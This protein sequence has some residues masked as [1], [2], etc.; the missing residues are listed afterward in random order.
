[1][2]RIFNDL[3]IMLLA[4]LWIVPVL[5]ALVGALFYF[6]APPPPM[7]ARLATGGPNGGYHA[8]GVKLQTELAREGFTLELVPS[9]GSLD[10]L[11]KLQA[12]EV[13]LALVQ[14]G[15][16][17]NLDATERAHLFGLGVMYQ[18]PVWLF[19]RQDVA[20]KRLADLQ[21]L[22]VAIGSADSG[23]QSLTLPLLEVNGMESRSLPDKWRQIG[24]GR[25]AK[26]L[27]NG[28]LDAAFFIGP[29]ENAL[30]QRLAANPDLQLLDLRRS[31]AYQARLPYLARVDVGEGMLNLA[32]NVPAHD[33]DTI[34]ALATLVANENFHSSLTPL[35]L[36][37][38]REVL[39]DGNLL[40]AA[41]QFPAASSSNLAS[42]DE[43]DYF[44][45]NG[46]PI[47]QRYLPFRIAS[48]A[49]R[50]IILAI[51]LL[52]LLFPLFKVVGP[53]Y[54]WRIRS[55][56]YRWYKHLR[57]IDRQLYLGKLQDPAAE[58]ARLVQLEDELAKVEVP[59]S[60]SGE[61]YDLH[62]HVR[63]MI[64]RLLAQQKVE[65]GVAKVA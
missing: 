47:L 59:L 17:L 6:V 51:P 56:I 26:A 3:K 28:E 33:T 45:R 61:L 8:F 55:R 25:A 32:R 38:A 35:L 42:L 31:A 39:K 27:A 30:V 60:Y 1:M 57:D 53:L 15:Q 21:S 16:E 19:A 52:V 62:V 29:A 13:E 7:S 34:A 36:A 9:A 44:Y 10:N 11:A 58:I 63:Y 64:K 24:G 18:E 37:A 40:D 4:N 65:R 23:T 12:G 46:L 22:R 43:A 50:Y 49:D 14:S 48:L 2:R 5:A 20:F 41:G 54:R